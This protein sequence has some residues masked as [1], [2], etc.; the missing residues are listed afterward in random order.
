M[1]S[2]VTNRGKVSF[3]IYTGSM[4]TDRLIVLMKQ[5]IKGKKRKIYL[6]LDNLKVHHSKI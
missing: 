3:M 4:N 5:L 2:T 1:I 6:I